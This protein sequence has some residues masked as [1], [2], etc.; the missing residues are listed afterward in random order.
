MITLQNII[1]P[2]QSVC[3]EDGLYVRLNTSAAFHAGFGLRLQP[4]GTARFD[5]YF[6][7]LNIGKWHREC[8]L[9][10]L[11]LSLSGTGTFVLTVRQAEAGAPGAPGAVMF[12]E[13]VTLEKSTEFLVDLS[14][15]HRSPPSSL[16]H[17]EL[18]ALT[19]S[20]FTGAAFLTN[21]ALQAPPRLAVSI[22]TFQREAEVQGTVR[23]LEKFLK[24]FDFK[25]HVHVFVVDN[26]HSA[27]IANT[28]KVTCLQNKNLGGAGGFARGLLEAEK[29]GFSHCAFMDDDATFH[30]ENIH[31][32]YVFLAL[33]RT[34]RAAVAGAMINNS[35]KWR[36]WENGAVFNR[37]CRPVSGGTDLRDFDEIL[38][39]EQK[40]SEERPFNFYG[41]WWFFAFPIAHVTHYP[42][43]FFV[44]GDDINFSLTND[45]RINVLNGVVSFQDGFSEKESPQFLYLDLR[46]HLVQHLTIDGLEISAISCARIALWFILRNAVKFQY[47]SCDAL[48]LAWRDVMR[49]PG[50]FTENADMVARRQDIDAMI[51]D[52]AWKPVAELD[53][54]KRRRFNPN[55]L[56]FIPLRW[57]WK[58][59]LNGHLFPFYN[60]W[61]NR[62]VVPSVQRGWFKQVWGASRITYLSHDRSKGYT[63]SQSKARFAGVVW[64][65]FVTGLRFVAGYQKL[66]RVY[67]GQFADMTSS[68]YW[69]QLLDIGPKK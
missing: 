10:G 7:A 36:L 57:A 43:P 3:S 68:A 13:E 59:T 44:R 11:Y 54:R 66:R 20:T 46:Y 56:W 22:T 67:K 33:S 65:V 14:R 55:R 27:K 8:D 62:V 51:K 32:A 23:R 30:L 19:K 69:A 52:E 16:I 12:Q 2:E 1:F 48:L 29:A 58:Y 61:A 28:K 39:M 64:Q 37:V 25:S 26:G 40:S 49:G 34:S 42:F 18:K 31:R 24:T 45:F 4:G 15:Y 63:V 38:E 5:T 53:L 17:F 9:D 60:A 35:T 6:N 21:A 50:F 41:G 47:E